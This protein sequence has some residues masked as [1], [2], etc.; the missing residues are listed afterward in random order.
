MITRKVEYK[1]ITKNGLMNGRAIIIN[2][3]SKEVYKSY[4]RFM[5]KLLKDK[6]ITDIQISDVA[7]D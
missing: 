1:V 6:K 4:N 3:D 5:K 2:P 7:S